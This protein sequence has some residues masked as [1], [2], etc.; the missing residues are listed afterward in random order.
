MG[1]RGLNGATAK[2]IVELA[3]EVVTESRRTAALPPEFRAKLE[4]LE[5]EL[6][7]AGSSAR[8]LLEK[9]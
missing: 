1:W 3:A 2:R 6:A 7:L 9:E 4:A 5:A 8:R